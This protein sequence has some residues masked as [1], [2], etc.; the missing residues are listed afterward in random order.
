MKQLT[1]FSIAAEEM[2]AAYG[3]CGSPRQQ[4][5]ANALAQCIR[6]MNAYR[7]TPAIIHAAN[8]IYASDDIELDDDATTSPAEDGSGCWVSAWVWVPS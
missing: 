8:E 4:E 3:N 7:A 2:L 6:V 1:D 5:A